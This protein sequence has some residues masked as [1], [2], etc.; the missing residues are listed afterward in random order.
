MQSSY[1]LKCSCMIL[2]HTSLSFTCTWWSSDVEYVSLQET[3]HQWHSIAWNYTQKLLSTGTIIVST[4]QISFGYCKTILQKLH[5]YKICSKRKHPCDGNL[6]A[7]PSNLMGATT[8]RVHWCLLQQWNTLAALT[9]TLN[10]VRASTHMPYD[11]KYHIYLVV[12]SLYGWVVK[13]QI[14]L[15]SCVQP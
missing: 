15:F 12:A 13:K 4:I 2:R 8:L 7:N 11:S 10:L 1:A 6:E 14:C 3:K 5:S 9:K